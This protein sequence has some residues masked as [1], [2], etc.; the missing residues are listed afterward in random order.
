MLSCPLWGQA[1]PSDPDAVAAPTAPTTVP[2]SIATTSAASGAAPGLAA[3]TVQS[4]SATAPE[5]KPST[6]PAAP[7]TVA[8]AATSSQ[9]SSAPAA[10]SSSVSPAAS[11]GPSD[12]DKGFEF[13]PGVTFGTL[14]VNGQT[15][16]RL[17]F[18]PEISY[19]RLGVGLNLELFLDQN[20]N[21]SSRAWDFDS[22]R[23]A[24]ESILRKI[25]YI[26]W[27][28]PGA[29]FY[30]RLGTLDGIE[31]GYGLVASDYGNMA[32]YPDYKELGADVQLN[33]LTGLGLDFE[34]IVN[35][36]EDLD[37]KG[38]FTA[39]KVGARPFK[40][41]GIPLF[42]GLVV[43]GGVAYDWNQYAGLRDQDGD[44]C[45]DAVDAAPNN[46]STCVNK[47]DISDLPDLDTSLSTGTN[48]ANRNAYDDARTD[49]VRNKYSARKPFGVWWAEASLP[50]VETSFF[51]LELHSAYAK[52]E[53]QDPAAVEAGW[54]AIPLGA[55]S[56]IGPVSLT[57][58]YR[59]F[60]QPFQPAYFDALYETQRAQIVDGVVTTKEL[61]IYGPG[62]QTG[63]L[64]GYFAS[65]SWDVFGFIALGASYSDLFASK[66]GESDLRSAGG[67]IGLGPQA[68]ALLQQKISLAEVYWRKDRI[69]MDTGTAN[70]YHYRDSFF[71]NSVNTAY[72]C[73]IGSQIASGLVLVVDRQ[74][75]FTRDSNG[76]LSKDNQMRI[77]TQLKF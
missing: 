30:A 58:E 11:K 77:E 6:A 65:A 62:A 18:T 24:L 7:P 63:K 3:T 1:L 20:Q 42:Q 2:S 23:N 70:G 4:P 44:G 60:D 5:T 64:Q 17:S 31:L 43:R 36:L 47:T 10:A 25:D 28:H 66:S 59:F 16:T 48:L 67:K 19:G 45:P 15:W 56:H 54:G 22:R 37:N 41:L 32:R 50:I 51:G 61:Q 72:G 34:A 9:A 29:P 73:R 69:G 39:F 13:H 53:T 57:A 26:R 12:A 49:S 8:P 40:P 68:T 33:N 46:A 76:K 74:T 27:D 75:S 38:P 14:T 35:N 52:P 21:L 55:N 71:G